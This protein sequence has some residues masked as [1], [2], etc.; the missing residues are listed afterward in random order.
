MNVA[1][2]AHHH[3]RAEGT[4]GYTAEL[5]ARVALSHD[6]TLYAAGVASAPPANVRVVRVPALTRFAY[7]TILTFPIGFAIK[8]REH[9]VVHAQGWVTGSADVVTAHVCVGAWREAL[10]ASG[11]P[12]TGG[13]RWFGAWVEQ[14]EGEMIRR[15]RL[16]IAPSEKVKADLA[17]CYGRRNDVVVIPHGFPQPR[18]LEDRHAARIALGLPRDAFIALYIGDWRK[19]LVNAIHAVHAAPKVHL[20][21]VSRRIPLAGRAEGRIHWRETIPGIETAYAAADVLLHP[22]IYDSFG[23]TVAEAMAYGIPVIVSDA[24]G[25]SELVDHGRSGW[26]VRGDVVAESAAALERLGDD[27]GLREVLAVTAREVAARHG[28]DETVRRT[29]EVY[30]RASRLAPRAS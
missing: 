30:E 12:A 29:V 28:W 6:V 18:L 9:D 2:V 26:I 20:L 24:A 13:E 4:G 23:L 25:V 17:R 19:G 21:V 16:V 5:V 14:Q 15:A 11:Q 1:I 22:T 3:N 10:R 27:H 8:R 7:G